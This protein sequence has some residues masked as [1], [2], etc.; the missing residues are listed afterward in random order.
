MQQLLDDKC[1]FCRASRVIP[2][3]SSNGHQ[4]LVEMDYEAGQLIITSCAYNTYMDETQL[5]RVLPL[6][7]C[8]KC[9]R[10][11]TECEEK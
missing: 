5:K 2:A 7:Y 1:E 6:K 8:P 11:I 4:L 3:Y 10:K 9:G